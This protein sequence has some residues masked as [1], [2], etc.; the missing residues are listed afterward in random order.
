MQ[1]LHALERQSIGFGS[2]A[3]LGA[4]SCPRLLGEHW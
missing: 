2:E 1:A 3:R 4:L